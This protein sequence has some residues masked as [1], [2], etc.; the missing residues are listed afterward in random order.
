M[1]QPS[2]SP[3]VHLELHT[4]NLARALQLTRMPTVWGRVWGWPRG[5]ARPSEFTLYDEME[6]A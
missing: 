2:P 5:E 6:E 1:I 3:V 4:G